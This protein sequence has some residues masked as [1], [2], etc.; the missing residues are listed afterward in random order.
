MVE[1]IKYNAENTEDLKLITMEPSV[2]AH[3]CNSTLQEAEAGKITSYRGQPGL[4]NETLSQKKRKSI[5]QKV[6]KPIK[7]KI[8]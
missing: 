5:Y 4:H 7:T 3:T 1:L 6:Y 8:L 2:V